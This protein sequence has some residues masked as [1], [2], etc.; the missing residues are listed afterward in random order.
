M[1]AVDRSLCW[2]E[3]QDLLDFLRL[4]S[5]SFIKRGDYSINIFLAT[6]PLARSCLIEAKSIIDLYHLKSVINWCQPDFYGLHLD[7]RFCFHTASEEE[8]VWWSTWWST[9]P[10]Q[11]GWYSSRRS[12]CFEHSNDL[13]HGIHGINIPCLALRVASLG[14]Q[15]SRPLWK[16]LSSSE[17]SAPPRSTSLPTSLPG[18]NGKIQEVQV[19]Q[20][21]TLLLQSYQLIIGFIAPNLVK[22]VRCHLVVNKPR[23]VLFTF[24]RCDTV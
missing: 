5:L 3:C 14:S 10:L 11:L 6:V 12:A 4:V 19:A 23:H 7:Q 24:M 2:T 17:A 15:W 9:F 21:G 20:N 16:F 22:L 18:L 1:T 13:L 8:E